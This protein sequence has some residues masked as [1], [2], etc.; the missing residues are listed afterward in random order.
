MIHEAPDD[1]TTG[2]R[3][4]YAQIMSYLVPTGERE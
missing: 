2:L 4:T 3:D 1:F